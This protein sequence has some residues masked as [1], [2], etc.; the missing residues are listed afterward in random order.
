MKKIYMI[1]KRYKIAT[2]TAI[3]IIILGLLCLTLYVSLNKG[4]PTKTI[5][6]KEYTLKYDDSW[7]LKSKKT[8]NILLK[9]NSGSTVSITISKLNDETRYL[10]IE[11]LIDEI[12]YNIEKQNSEYKLI[13]KDKSKITKN[14][15]D[16]YKLLYENSDKQVLITLF[17][18]SDKFVMI[19]YEANDKYFD[20]LLDNVNGMIYDFDIIDKKFNVTNKIKLKT[21]NITYKDNKE[22]SNMISKTKKYEIANNHYYV[23][24]SIPEIFKLN[25]ISSFSGFFSYRPDDSFTKKIDISVSIKSNIYRLLDKNAFLNV[26]SD[27]KSIKKDKQNSDFNEAVSKFDSEYDSYIYKNSYY[28]KTKRTKNI[29]VDKKEDGT[30]TGAYEEEDYKQLNENVELLYALDRN[31]TLSIKISSK[32]MA[33]PEK[34]VN[35]I[36]IN[37]VKNYSSY[38]KKEYDG[39]Y[40]I[41]NLKRFSDTEKNKIDSIIIKIPKNYEEIDKHFLT[42]NIYEDRYYGLNYN[43]ENDIYD[44]EIHYNLVNLEDM[45]KTVD[46]YQSNI[47]KNYGEYKNYQQVSDITIN[48]KQ[49]KVFDGGYTDLSGV[50]F[51]DKNRNKYYINKKLLFYK[52]TSKGYVMIEISGNGKEIT[53]DILNDVTNIVHEIKDF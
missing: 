33:I 32:D 3:I 52:L 45:Q 27:S 46:I 14:R 51:T 24:Y 49:F 4:S 42:T 43:E 38:I 34:L 48:D 17:K 29:T 6:N 16:G 2:I 10:S 12:I 39:D 18:K 44:Y 21:S 7:S 31:H 47:K 36:K 26:Y 15:Y 41:G 9:H 19:N 35:S 40:L 25:T 22:F 11:E 53:H 50:M 28:Y 20:I 30:S 23:N 5:T 13:S 37:N 1:L 8:D